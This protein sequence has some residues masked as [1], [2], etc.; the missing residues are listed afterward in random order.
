MPMD[1]ASI[2]TSM[3]NP[4]YDFDDETQTGMDV[5]GLWF[6]YRSVS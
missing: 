1:D 3:E 4:V 2:A 6:I 5:I